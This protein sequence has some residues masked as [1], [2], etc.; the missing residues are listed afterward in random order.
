MNDR[1][2]EKVMLLPIVV[3]CLARLHIHGGSCAVFIDFDMHVLQ[4]VRWRAHHRTYRR[5]LH[6]WGSNAL[7]TVLP[8]AYVDSSF[9]GH[10]RGRAIP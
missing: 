7:M 3:S 2:T 8:D 1:S 10:Q 6:V 4:D 9:L 5:N